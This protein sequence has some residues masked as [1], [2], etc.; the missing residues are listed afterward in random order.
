MLSKLTGRSVLER[1][2]NIGEHRQCRPARRY[3]RRCRS[4][5]GLRHRRRCGSNLRGCNAPFD[6]ARA[7]KGTPNIVGVDA[8]SSAQSGP[9]THDAGQ[10][11]V[12]S[13]GRIRIV[14]PQG[15]RRVEVLTKT[16]AHRQ[17]RLPELA[18]SIDLADDCRATE[19]HDGQ[20]PG[21]R[22]ASGQVA[23][24]EPGQLLAAK[25]AGYRHHGR[26]RDCR[27]SCRSVCISLRPRV[28][29]VTG[30]DASTEFERRQGT[31]GPT[32]KR[33]DK[34]LRSLLTAGAVAVLRHARNRPTAMASGLERCWR[35]NRSNLQRSHWPT[36]PPA[37][38]GR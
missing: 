18:R 8:A 31:L 2:G 21:D 7:G 9:A 15:L 29:D 26:K 12:R 5:G 36:R 11:L 34:Y 33:C 19:R 16:I 24:A 28:R 1:Q 14:A 3:Q 4:T 37:P 13:L 20:D 22:G 17:E 30:D 10:C 32:S 6:A 25:R 27:D 38:S 23:S 35:A